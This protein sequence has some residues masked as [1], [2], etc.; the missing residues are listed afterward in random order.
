MSRSVTLST[1]SVS[2]SK[3]RLQLAWDNKDVAHD[4]LGDLKRLL[5]ALDSFS[6]EQPIPL[7]MKD[8]LLKLSQ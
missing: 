6:K 1:I 8:R 7:D 4:M 2:R 3:W 5:G